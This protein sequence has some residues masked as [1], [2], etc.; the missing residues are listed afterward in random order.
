MIEIPQEEGEIHHPPGPGVRS[1][2]GAKISNTDL[3]RSARHKKTTKT[4]E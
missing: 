2:W 1:S 4:K 3:K